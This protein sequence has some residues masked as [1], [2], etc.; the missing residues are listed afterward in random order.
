MFTVFPQLAFAAIALE[1]TS[2]AESVNGVSATTG[3]STPSVLGAGNLN[4]VFCS[5]NGAT[6]AAS[7]V[8]DT[9]GNTYSALTSR[10]NTVYGRIFYAKNTVGHAANVATCNLSAG[11]VAR[12]VITME[13]SGID[14]ST[15]FDV[16][17]SGQVGGNT[18]VTSG[19]FTTTQ[20]NEVVVAFVRSVG[21]QGTFTAGA[22]FTLRQNDG[23]PTSQSED[24]TVSSILTG[25]TA[26]MSWTAGR[27]A[28]ILVASFKEGSAAP[29]AIANG[30][31][32]RL[33]EGFR[34]KVLGG[35]ILI[36]QAP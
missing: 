9:A 15:P 3:T 10:A 7:S 18:T 19:A 25:S 35:K 13:Y 11:A 23:I 20:A 12:S 30:R 8:T 6:A 31:T 24:R 4:V 1:H 26:S 27:D 28:V 21:T 17:A 36:H 34:I 2:A 22:N 33:F 29:A 16:E 14:T 32:L 5:H